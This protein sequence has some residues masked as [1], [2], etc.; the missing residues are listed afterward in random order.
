MP[1]TNPKYLTLVCRKL[2]LR[3]L[4]LKIII[5]QITAILFPG[6]F[7]TTYGIAVYLGHS[8][9]VWPYISDTGKK[10]PG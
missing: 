6:T 2:T 4:T 3:V 7:L 10:G 8:D 1:L 9:L 5:G